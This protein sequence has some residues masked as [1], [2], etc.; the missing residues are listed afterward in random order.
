M[1]AAKGV[2]PLSPASAASVLSSSFLLSPDQS[3]AVVVWP[4]PPCS[5]GLGLSLRGRLFCWRRGSPVVG[6]CVPSLGAL[7]PLSS[8]PARPVLRCGEAAALQPA[9]LAIQLV[10]M[11]PPCPVRGCRL[12]C[13]LR[14]G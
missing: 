9:A 5:Q 6:V 10:G 4:R 8:P 12:R 14:V 2:F 13:C 3:H 1:H 7:C 11:T